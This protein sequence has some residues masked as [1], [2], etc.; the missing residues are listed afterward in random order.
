MEE[1]T[2]PDRFEIVG[3][4]S[5]TDL[6]GVK[7]QK[8]I[9]FNY[10]FTR[11]GDDHADGCVQ[12]GGAELS[13]RHHVLF[14]WIRCCTLT[15]TMASTSWTGIPRDDREQERLRLEHQLFRNISFDDA[16]NASIDFDSVEFPRNPQQLSHDFTAPDLSIRYP[17]MQ[18]DGETRSTT[19]HHAHGVTFRT[20]LRGRGTRRRVSGAESI[21][22]YDPDRPLDVLLQKAA[23]LSILA[24]SPVRVMVLH[25][26]CG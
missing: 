4:F 11:K 13:R 15:S 20:G 2:C 16:S 7:F 1:Q 9:R 10:V 3:R 23:D 17:G 24:D 18:E 6:Q 21:E 25:A 12:I 22:E 5:M 8:M 26:S 14:V 19:A